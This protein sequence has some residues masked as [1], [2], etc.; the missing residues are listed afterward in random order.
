MWTV[1]TVSGRGTQKMFIG[2]IEG[3]TDEGKVYLAQ[4]L[5]FFFPLK[6]IML[7]SHE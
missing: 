4:I 3:W 1:S 6:C 7:L 5:I 2:R